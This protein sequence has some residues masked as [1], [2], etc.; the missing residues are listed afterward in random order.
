MRYLVLMLL[1]AATFAGNDV[2]WAK[3]NASLGVLQVPAQQKVDQD[4]T[5]RDLKLKPYEQ[6]RYGDPLTNPRSNSP[7]L[8]N[9]PPN[10]NVNIELD[11]SGTYFNVNETLNDMEYRP[12]TL[13][14]YNEYRKYLFQKQQQDYWRSLSIQQDGRDAL[15]GKDGSRLIPPIYLGKVADRLFGGSTMEFKTSGSVLLDFGGL[16][17]RVDNPQIPVRQQRNGGFNFDQQIGMA[18]EGKIGDKLTVSGNFDT[19]SAFQFEQ[20]Y[21]LSYTAYDHDII[22]DVQVGN[23]SFPVSNSLITGAQNLFGVYTKMRFGKLYVS[24]IFSSQRGSVETMTIRNGSQAAEFEMQA[25]NYEANRNF[26][27]SQFFRDNYERAL[28]NLP[29]INS[30]VVVTRVKVFVTNRNNDTQN[31][32]SLAAFLDLGESTPYNSSW[33]GGGT[34]NGEAGNNANSLYNEIAQLG[35]ARNPDNVKSSLEGFNGMTNG[36]D[37]EVLRSAREL[38]STEYTLDPLLGY[39]TLNAPLRNDEI[40]AVAYEYTYNGQTFKVGELNEDYTNLD[41]NAVVYMKMLSPSTIRTDLPTWDLM[42]KNIYQLQATQIQKENFNLRVVYKDDASGVDNPNLPDGQNTAN[43]PLVRLMNADQLNPSQERQPDSKYDYV[44]GITIHPQE[45]RIIFPVLEP[46]GKTL[47]DLFEPSESALVEKYVFTDLYNKTQADAKLNTLQNK[48]FIKG[49][50]QS[51]SS[52]DI[53]LPGINISENSVVVSVGGTSLTEGVDYTVDYQFGRVKI[54]NEGVL[55]SNKDIQIQYERAD[56]FNF[57]TRNLAG[58]DLEYHFSKDL[59]VSATL[60]HLNEK[61]LIRR[62]AVG[63]EPTRNTLWGTSVD[64]RTDSRFLTKAIDAIPGIST[65]ENSTVV[66]K[67]E[68]AQLVPSAPKLVGTDGVSYIDDFE[69]A[70]VPY[71]YTRTPTQWAIGSTPVDILNDYVDP[72]DERSYNYKRAKMAWYNID[73]VFYFSGGSG[74]SQRPSNITS[75]VLQNHY[76][77]LIPYNEVFQGKQREQITGNEISFDIA[78]Y[79]DERGPYNYRTDLNSDG[80]LPNPTENFGAITKAIT[81]D[82]DF[83]N[84]NV[85]Y[86]EFWL[87]DPFLDGENGQVEGKNNTTGGKLFFNLGNISEDLVPD[88]RHFFENGLTTN[89]DAM[90]QTEDWGF[91]PNTQYLNN[92]FN[93]AVPRDAQDVGFDGL[94]SERERTFLSDYL[95]ALP[96]SIRSSIE[97]D[98]SGDDFRYYLGSYA[99]ENDFSILQRYK[100]FNGPDGNSPELS[101]GSAFPASSSNLPDNEDLNKDN[102]VSDL[103]Q[104]FQYELDLKPSQLNTSHPY[105]VDEVEAEAPESGERVKWYQFRIPIRGSHVEEIGGNGLS[106]KSIRFMRM[107]LTGWEQ[108]V[109]LRMVNFQLVGAQWRPYTASSLED[110][111]KPQPNSSVEVSSVN[112]EENGLDTGE[113][114]PYVLPPG[115]ERDY[116]ATSTVTRRI[117]EQSIQMCVSGL[118]PGTSQAVFK[119]FALNLVN[120]KRIKMELHAE[121]D[122]ARDDEL[123]AYL[124]LGTDFT[125][126]YYE[127]EVP[128]D[129]TPRGSNTAEAIWPRDNEIDVALE[130]L[131]L[132]KS[133]RDKSGSST[134]EPYTEKIRNYNI[135]VVGRPDLSAVKMAIIGV[136]NPESNNSLRDV[137]IWANELRVTDYNTFSGWAVNANLDTKLADFATLQANVRYTTVGFGG[138]QDKIGSRS[139]DETMMYGVASN[140]NVDK[141]WLN[142]IGVTMPLYVSYDRST[143][144]PYFD[145]KDPDVPLDVSIAAFETAE[146]GADYRKIVQDYSDAFSINI[147]GLRKKKMREGAKLYPWDIENWTFSGAYTKRFQRN[148]NTASMEDVQ[149]KIGAAYTYQLPFDGFEPFK[150]IKAFDGKYLQLIKDF[151]FNPLPTSVTVRGDLDRRYIR[152]QLRDSNLEIDPSQLF[153]E[154]TF[155]FNRNYNVSWDLTNSLKLDYAATANAIIDEPFGEM[156]QAA[157]DTIW[158]NLSDF[159]RMKQFTQSFTGTYQLPLDK[160]PAIDWVSSDVRYVGGTSWVAATKGLEDFGNTLQNNQQFNVNGKLDFKKLYNKSSYLKR[161]NKETRT[162]PNSSNARPSRRRNNRLAPDHPLVLKK[163]KLEDKLRKLK[164]KQKKRDDRSAKKFEEKM[165]EVSEK[166]TEKQSAGEDVTELEQELESLQEAFQN[167]GEKTRLQKKIEKL[168]AKLEGVN[169]D[170]EKAKEEGGDGRGAGGKIADGASKLLTMVK[171]VNGTYSQNNSTTLPGYNETPKLFG[172]DQDWNSPGLPFILGSQDFGIRNEIQPYLVQNPNQRT[173]FQ[174]RRSEDIQIR[175]SVEPVSSL[176]ITLDATRTRQNAYTE[177]IRYDDQNNEFI[178][179]SP[180]RT[181]SRGISYFTLRTAFTKDDA[182]NVSPVFEEFVRNRDVIQQRLS[183]ANPGG[184]YNANSQDVLIPAFIAAYTGRDV[185]TID[186]NPFPDVPIPNWQISYDGLSK[187]PLFSDLFKSVTISHQYRS[188][189]DVG[190]YTSS[191]TYG[192]GTVGLDKNE[193]HSGLSSQV[194][195]QGSYIPIFVMNQVNIDEQFGPLLGVSVRFMNDFSLKFDY[196]KARRLSLNLSNAQVSELRNNDFVVDLGYTKAGMKLPFR[197]QGRTVLLKNDVTFRMAFTIRDTETFQRIIDE[198]DV[199]TAGN[200]NFQLKPTVNYVLNDRANLQLYFERTINEPKVSTA[201][202]R[203]T[204]AFGFQLRYDLTQQ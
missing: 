96:G 202:R 89:D 12:P 108:P 34:P 15:P 84:I 106:Y 183:V 167:E 159:G 134:T 147:S 119:N 25:D 46:F 14:P 148:M 130:E 162:R 70:E 118:E 82:V 138:I 29:I 19:K 195:D 69:G 7:L 31:L 144:D 32:R 161:V 177:I 54:L 115:F 133:K 109:V 198:P 85:Q 81:H 181:G 123:T 44:E 21:N 169:A 87:L 182:G 136:R 194:D 187:L 95:S 173:P 71:D 37:F 153:F 55:N 53:T 116:D 180:Q 179:Q 28:Q 43:I 93:S 107:F 6:D 78:Y 60:L 41:A 20:R 120:Y 58:V 56:L 175:A 16:W 165:N 131:Y 30:G 126:N 1:C 48:Y 8:L 64:Y 176:K 86:I 203:T 17:Q 91:T 66:F 61:P 36:T 88:G 11:S 158:D 155:F 141:L 104:Y 142:R 137:C 57:Q 49:S 113:G 2:V 157:R 24:G 111:T 50:V 196:K 75:E 59:K 13:I 124:R 129:I 122:N 184:T 200:W 170:I 103:N 199:I 98:P 22:Q 201:F 193:S 186:F 163:Q 94:S 168:E 23:V 191:L 127:I 204:T 39:I 52:G 160:I 189:Y 27:L 40:L 140:I 114:I 149:W 101:G 125:Q 72:T 99:D 42:M 45:G 172:F 143:S 33:I 135:S 97:E 92:A 121:S 77:R 185:N 76:S 197:A 156:N 74:S 38:T 63:S 62:I 51:G 154:K 188:T 192:A 73:N 174:Q 146:A 145:P 65:T 128:L 100:S 67:G 105:I 35:G 18:L 83:D 171:D 26:F 117:N 190:S 132:I 151:N 79:P 150:N 152:T 164:D 10:S 4:T 5:K 110:L 139:M 166:I 68:F 178:F 9:T 80:S 112:I 102:T 47:D 90:S 3:P